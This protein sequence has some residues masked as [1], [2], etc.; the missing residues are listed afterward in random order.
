ME[1]EGGVLV[2]NKVGIILLKE[3]K[4]K[5]TSPTTHVRGELQEPQFLA[6]PERRRR[7]RGIAEPRVGGAWLEPAS[8]MFFLVLERRREKEKG[9]GGW[10]KKK[11]KKNDLEPPPHCGDRNE[12]ALVH[13]NNGSSW[14]RLSHEVIEKETF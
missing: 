11:K 9:G 8:F 5:T 1:K 14:T 4:K 6:G 10:T 12:N 3:K 2:R 7:L 13:E